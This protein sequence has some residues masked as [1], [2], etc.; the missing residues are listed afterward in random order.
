MTNRDTDIGQ[1]F[2]EATKYRLIDQGDGN[3]QSMMGIPPDFQPSLGEQGAHNE[4]HPFK[5]YTD[6][7]TLELPS[8]FEPFT[9]P[10]LE[11]ITMSGAEDSLD[12]TPDLSALARISLL[13]NG[14]LKRGSHGTG[15]EIFYR[16]AGGTGARYHLE[17]YY[18]TGDLEGLDAGVY[19]YAADTHRLGR[20]RSGDFRGSGC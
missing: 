3:P 15:R 19:H 6:L 2:H 11:A 5:V 14:I 13:S 9:M 8:E 18:V 20:I 12:A 17:L 7:D 4:P 1:R 10:L 16:A